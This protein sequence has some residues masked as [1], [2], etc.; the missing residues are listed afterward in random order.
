MNQFYAKSA[1]AVG[2]HRRPA[3]S[4]SL[5]PVMATHHGDL[6]CGTAAASAQQPSERRWKD[7]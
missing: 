4:H 2:A 3:P 7:V 6:S 1:P 5:L